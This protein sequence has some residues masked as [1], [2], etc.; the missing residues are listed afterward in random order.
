MREPLAK[1]L[2]GLSSSITFPRIPRPLS[3][4]LIA[5]VWEMFDCLDHYPF[6]SQWRVHVTATSPFLNRAGLAIWK[7]AE[8]SPRLSQSLTD[9]SPQTALRQSVSRCLHMPRCLNTGKNPP[10]Y[11]KSIFNSFTFLCIIQSWNPD[12][13]QVGSTLENL[14]SLNNFKLPCTCTQSLYTSQ[15]GEPSQFLEA[16]Q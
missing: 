7:Y 14:K 12:N 13:F 10:F 6:V 15:T 16:F 3:P 4:G 1:R 2:T 9:W 5:C 11:F 8:W